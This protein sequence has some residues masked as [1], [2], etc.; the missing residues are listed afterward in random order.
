MEG[1][2]VPLFSILVVLA[3]SFLKRRDQNSNRKTEQQQKQ[4]FFKMDREGIKQ[5]EQVENQ[6]TSPKN[7]ATPVQTDER[8]KTVKIDQMDRLR[9]NLDVNTEEQ[10]RKT[11]KNAKEIEKSIGRKTDSLHVERKSVKGL[12]IKKRLNNTGLRQSI[13]MAEVLGPP[14][15]KKPHGQVKY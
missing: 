5:A 3:S 12:S 15:A 2:I 9:D 7:K 1:F 4:S 6:N 14:R 10:N 13:V 11:R 8:S